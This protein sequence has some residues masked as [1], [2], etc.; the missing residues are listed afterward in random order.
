[1]SGTVSSMEGRKLYARYDL[2]THDEARR[3]SRPKETQED[4][5]RRLE[6]DES[7]TPGQIALLLGMSRYSV[8]HWLKNGIRIKGYAEPWLPRYDTTVGG[9]RVVRPEVVRQ[10]LALR[11][12]DLR[13]PMVAQQHPE[14]PDPPQIDEPESHS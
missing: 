3:M 14:N 10:I 13:G 12:S 9:Y 7:L 4:V 8:D 1:M 5:E 11:G 2:H 6:A